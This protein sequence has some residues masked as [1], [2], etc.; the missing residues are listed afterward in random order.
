[1][2]FAVHNLPSNPVRCKFALPPPFPTKVLQE[3]LDLEEVV[4]TIDR[5]STTGH[6]PPSPP[7]RPAKRPS[8]KVK[9]AR[10][11]DRS[12]LEQ[13]NFVE[14]SWLG[15]YTTSLPGTIVE[16][17][18]IVDFPRLENGVPQ[19]R[20]VLLPCGLTL[21]FPTSLQLKSRWLITATYHP[22][23]VGKE[24]HRLR[25]IRAYNPQGDFVG[26]AHSHERIQTE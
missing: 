5:I 6:R 23:P 4:D 9:E 13:C 25:L 22:Q 16:S 18:A 24:R 3:A 12:R 26:A 10:A 20:T 17:H 19:R 15:S 11:R 2:G 8:K 21:H 1:M 14:S 7:K